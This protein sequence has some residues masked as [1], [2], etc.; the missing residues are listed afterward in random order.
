[1]GHIRT[2]S[3]IKGRRRWRPLLQVVSLN[4]EGDR[5]NP[6]I[7][8]V[9]VAEIILKTQIKISLKCL[10]ANAVKVNGITYRGIVPSSLEQFIE[11]HGKG[12]ERWEKDDEYKKELWLFCY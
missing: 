12:I 8:F 3:T 2:S 1:M 6:D 5:A 11:L 9:G 7:I 4:Q 10:A